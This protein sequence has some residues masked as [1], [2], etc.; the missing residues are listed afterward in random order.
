M[1]F[2]KYPLL[3]L[4]L[5]FAQI[6]FAQSSSDCLE[7]H[8]DNELT[9]TRHGKEISLYIDSTKFGNSVHGD[10]DCTDCHED[11]DPEELPHKPGK[12]IYKVNCGNCHEDIAEQQKTDIHQRLKDRIKHPPTCVTCHGAHYVKSPKDCK[13]PARKYCSKCHQSRVLLRPYHSQPKVSDKK[14]TECHKIDSYKHSLEKSIHKELLCTDCHICVANKG[15]TPDKLKHKNAPVANCYVCHNKEAS[16]H[17]KS[18]HGIALREGVDE[19]AKCWDCHGSHDILPVNNKKSPA[20]ISNIAN[21]CAKCHA[22]SKL[23]KKFNFTASMPVQNYLASVHGKLQ[24]KGDTT[25]ATCTT[26]HGVHDIKNAAQPGSKISPYNLPNTCEKCHP[27]EVLRYKQSIHWI[28]VEKGFKFAPVCNDCHTEHG[29]RKV[30]G[31][32]NRKIARIMQQQT[33]V[34][35][36]Q[37]KILAKRVGLKADEPYTYEDSYHGL[38]TLRGDEDAAMCIDCHNAHKILPKQDP[39]SSVN[40]KNV[41]NTCK[42]CHPEATQVFSE[43]Y[44]HH[45]ISV[46]SNKAQDIVNTF[47]FWLILF[48]IGGMFVHNLII[49]IHDVIEKRKRIKERPTI[50][51]LTKNEVIQHIILF[52]SFIILAITGF[53]LKFSQSWWSEGLTK[54]GLNEHVRQLVHRT[55][56]VIL[57]LTGIYHV[58]YLILTKR[59]RF[60]LSALIPKFKDITQASQNIAY[61]L[62]LSKLKPEF[63]KFDYTEKAEYWALIWGTVIMGLTGFIL[64]FP[65]AVGNWAP[66][67]LIKVCQSIH[68]YEAVLA[69]LAILIWHWFFVIFHPK[70]YPM[71]LTWVD[72]QMSLDEYKEHH[73]EDF[74]TIIKEWAE[75][76]SNKKPADEMGYETKLF[77]ENIKKHGNDPDRVLIDQLKSDL[78]LRR[79]LEANI[80]T[81]NL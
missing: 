23:E 74:K 19:A 16:E 20:Y 45:N 55:A 69:S 18:I 62:G 25:A 28:Y 17:K 10:L 7:C 58:I 30:S 36:H 5:G 31:K 61:Y 52:T 66:I 72:G 67:W 6:V 44:S 9:Y 12:N 81:L 1:N 29:I 57:I 53:A 39:E 33:C 38:A 75:I 76:K 14:C 46:A 65:T 3:L 13:L 49:Y 80:G 79:W 34:V 50:P 63:D 26:C 24:S 68:F 21:T 27:K 73:T 41:K 40:V 77:L 60:V 64:W 42:K 35:C 4:L 47:Y 8:S 54:I 43:S 56:A 2:I 70:E 32:N 71:N 11:F 22:G 78:E 48:T 51:R 37:N 59:G 15:M